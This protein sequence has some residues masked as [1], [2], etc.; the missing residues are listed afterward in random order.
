MYW[1]GEPWPSSEERAEVCKEDKLRVAIPTDNICVFCEDKFG[2][3]DQGVV[4]GS[5]SE[6]P[7]SYR[8][9]GRWVTAAH[10]VCMIKNVTGLRID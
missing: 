1:F 2:P 4:M 7:M 10:L 9:R 5:S 3:G 8:L 6:L